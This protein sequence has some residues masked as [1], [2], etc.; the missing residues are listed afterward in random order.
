[1]HP[2]YSIIAFTTASGAGYGL[3]FAMALVAL[4]GPVPASQGFAIA[5]FTAVFVLVS[6]GLLAST[7]HLGPP[8]RACTPAWRRVAR[9]VYGGAAAAAG[10]Q[11]KNTRPPLGAGVAGWPSSRWT[12]S[13]P[14]AWRS[15]A[16]AST[17]MTMNGGIRP[18]AETLSA[19]SQR[20]TETP[21]PNP[22]LSAR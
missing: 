1:M 16:A 10:A 22:R 13:S 8:P 6:A 18:R 15:L 5:G 17:S 3:L 19:T 9:S 20:S 14:A 2:A 11:R 7:A 21:Y 4:A 12:I